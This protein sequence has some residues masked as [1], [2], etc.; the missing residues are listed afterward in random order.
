MVTS[1][2]LRMGDPQVTM[3]VEILSHGPMT[4]MIWGYPH[5][6]KPPY[7]GVEM[8]KH[9]KS[10]ISNICWCPP[11]ILANRSKIPSSI[12][13]FEDWRFTVTI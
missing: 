1:V 10:G 3:V 11:I 7:V 12:I 4:W 2:C 13:H 6:R 9:V 5:F 8:V